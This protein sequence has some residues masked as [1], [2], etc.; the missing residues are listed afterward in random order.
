MTC[1]FGTSGTQ[2][3]ELLRITYSAGSMSASL[4]MR[5]LGFNQTK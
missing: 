1:G 2:P 5:A 4:V 3:G